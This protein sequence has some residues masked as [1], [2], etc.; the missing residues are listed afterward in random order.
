MAIPITRH[1]ADSHPSQDLAQSD[2]NSFT[3]LR[4]ATGLQAF[5]KLK[6]EIGEDGAR[7]RRNQHRE[8]MRFDDL[9]GL[10]NERDVERSREDEFL[11]CR[12]RSEQCRQRC[13]L[14]TYITVGQQDHSGDTCTALACK[15]A[16]ALEG[17]QGAF[18]SSGDF[19]C[20]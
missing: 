14:R 15:L 3:I 17:Y 10:D 12:G 9:S 20:E 18:N 6:S 13:T 2:L 7:S 11:P 5:R 8:V 16:N 19:E 4:A 1:R